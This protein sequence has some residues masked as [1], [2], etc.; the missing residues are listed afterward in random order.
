MILYCF[1]LKAKNARDYNRLKRKFYYHLNKSSLASAPWK[2]KS[3]LAIPNS[4]ARTADAFFRQWRG[5]IEV[6]K[7]WVARAKELD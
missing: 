1:D 6:H 7:I 5:S 2:T 4:L 3:V